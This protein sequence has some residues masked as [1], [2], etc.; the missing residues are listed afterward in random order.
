MQQM[1]LD[2]LEGSVSI[3]S[4]EKLLRR[5]RTVRNK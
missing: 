5:L 2:D 3:E 1:K 4:E